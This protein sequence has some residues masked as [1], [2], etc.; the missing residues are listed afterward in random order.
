MFKK[1]QNSS[2]LVSFW[3]FFV[4][5]SYS[6]NPD[7]GFDLRYKLGHLSIHH[8]TMAHLPKSMAEAVEFTWFQHTKGKREYQQHYKFPTL[9]A[10]FFYGSVG[11]DQLLGRYSGLYGFSE[12]P[13][14]KNRIFETN[15]K[16]ATGVA[17]TNK[18]FKN[19]PQNVAIGSYL[20]AIICVGMKAMVRINHQHL[21]IGIDMT[22]FS[23]GAA[24]LPNYGIN[25]PYISLGYGR[26]LKSISYKKLKI[27]SVKI[28]SSL[29]L[30]KWLFTT[31]GIY[32]HKE[33]NDIGGKKY[34]VYALNLSAKRFFNHKA[35][36]ELD[37]DVISKQAI[38]GY[39]PEISKSQMDILQLGIYTA[40]L[41]PFDR[42]HFVFGM[43]A[44][45]RDKYKPEDP[46][47]HRIGCR[48]QFPNGLIGNFTLKTHFG[49]ADYLEFGLG[50]TIKIKKN[51]N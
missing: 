25:I 20:N 44:Y 15:I 7:V 42:F 47:Y 9:G 38:F 49:R 4:S 8:P 46:V 33:V 18:C 32:G 6:Q 40:Y 1:N 22:H 27:D 24:Q 2:L 13:I 23:N 48:Y 17:L 39:F 34:S 37:L 12:L 19:E 21:S 51:E 43:G 31:L 28:G 29:P 14:I 26:Y 11:N 30:N 41:V 45:I 10:T 36:W 16:L 35:G 3:I 50:Y 5:M